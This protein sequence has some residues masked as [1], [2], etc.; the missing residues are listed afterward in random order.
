MLITFVSSLITL[1]GLLPFPPLPGSPLIHHLFP[2]TSH[3]FCHL[4]RIH[5]KTPKVV[6]SEP[7]SG[8]LNVFRVDERLA[9][10]V[11]IVKGSFDLGMKPAIHLDGRRVPG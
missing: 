11:Q 4:L 5:L 9:F 10:G 6:K 7:V 3:S 8:D 1:A 2:R